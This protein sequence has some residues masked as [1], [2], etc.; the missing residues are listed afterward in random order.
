MTD[1]LD[2][3]APEF[4]QDPWPLYRELRATTPV[5]QAPDGF[6]I[7]TRHADCS[8]ILREP[9]WSVDRGNLNAESLAAFSQ[10]NP[11]IQVGVPLMLFLDPPEH[12]RLRS[13]VSKA[14]TPKVVEGLR[15]RI[16]QLVDEL[17]DGV[18][19]QGRMDV[20]A[21]LA[22]PL[23]VIVICELLGVPLDDRDQFHGW[24][25]DASRLLDGD[26]D[27]ETL[28]RGIFAAMSVINYFNEL[29]EARRTTPGDDLLS[30][31]VAAEEEGER[32]SH[33]EL[34]ATTVLLFIAGHETTMNLIGN[35]TYALL[36]HPDQ[37]QRLCD[38][39]ALVPTAVEEF[40]RFDGPVHLTA[41]I[42]L[43]DM[44][45]GGVTI[46][47]GDRVGAIVSAA[48]RDPAQFDRPD[49][50][51]VGRTPNR[52]LAF[53]AGPHFCLGAALARVE[54][55][56]AFATMVRRFSGLELVT[57]D[58]RYRDHFV[59]R[60]LDRLEVAFTAA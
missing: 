16:Q 25:T 35:G 34:I 2:P 31:L 53:S 51:D 4:R 60:G 52:H 44:D 32:L 24:S 37:L 8:R 15:P 56:V 40:L 18:E 54:A 22:Y 36:K 20:L 50:L 27:S 1:V 45:F 58:V 28:Q 43:T 48:N 11:A 33:E 7:L 21:D 55:Q 19:E 41:R 23:P 17:L 3:F 49:E 9:G 12:T 13:L 42:P 10:E 59:L 47:A 57:E 46:R 5:F 26:L 30:A 39:P 14:F 6:W 29:I 38:D